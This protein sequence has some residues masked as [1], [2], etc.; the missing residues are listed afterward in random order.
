[1]ANVVLASV[2]IKKSLREERQVAA[3]QADFIVVL[4]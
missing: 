2:Q 1:L 3:A 4:S